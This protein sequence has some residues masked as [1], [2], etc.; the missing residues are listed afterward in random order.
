MLTDV[1][2]FHFRVSSGCGDE[3]VRTNIADVIFGQFYI[4][5]MRDLPTSAID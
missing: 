2:I 5:T 1:D 3:A 4:V